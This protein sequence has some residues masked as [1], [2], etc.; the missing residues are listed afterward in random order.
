MAGNT[1]GTVFRITTFGESH[2]QALGVVI[3]GCPA[4]IPIK[5][6]EIQA[7]LNRRRPGHS[8]NKEFN[9][10]VTSRS[11]A[12]TAEIMSGVFE[13]VSIGSPITLLIHNTN[14][15]SKDYSAL[16]K[17]FR[18]G[19]ADYTYYKKYG[20]YD[21]RG[22]GRSS[23]RETAARVAAG[24]VAQA[25]LKAYCPDTHIEIIAHTV[26]ACGIK[27]TPLPL[28]QITKAC[29]EENA[30]RCA[31]KKSADE[32]L[33]TITELRKTG[34]SGGGIIEC[35]VKG[36]PAGWGEPVF[37][38]LEAELA[39]AI[40]SI[41]AVKGIEFGSGFASA[42]IKGSEQNDS[43]LTPNG[44]DVHFKTN[45]AGGILGGIST[46]NTILFRFAVKPVPS[47]FLKQQTLSVT[48]NNGNNTYENT[49]ICIEG[50]HD[51]CLC[52]RIV[53]VAEAMVAVTLTDMCLRHN[54]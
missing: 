24:A 40:M 46:G 50:R 34:D 32:M 35:I 22:G 5:Q 49:D 52:P 42:G 37:D 43:M 45:N 26:E 51:V 17:T 2:G 18:P 38:K 44:N 15:H 16:A 27:A 47:I 4:G 39:K 3:D 9:P 8:G 48:I 53:P 12:D 25:V 33:K 54:R 20:T 13:G 36:V 1:F 41:G 6:E 31:D 21:Y 23:G 10:A 19:H 29:I 14:Q 30:M 28:E 7:E 11:E